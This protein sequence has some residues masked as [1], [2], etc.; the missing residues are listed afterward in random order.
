MK[1]KV[2][3]MFYSLQGEGPY[4]GRPAVFLRMSNCTL[5]CKWCDTVEVWRQGNEFTQAELMQQ[6]HDRGFIEKLQ[7]G[8]LLILTG[9]SPLMQ[10]KAL[11]P[12]LEQLNQCIKEVNEE[13]SDTFLHIET[14]G[15]IEPEEKLRYLTAFT[16]VSPK[17]S[18]SGEP[19]VKRIRR[20]V[21]NRYGADAFYTASVFFKFVVADAADFTEALAL[22]KELHP[23]Y[24]PIS[25]PDIRFTANEVGFM[26]CASTEEDLKSVWATIQLP[27]LC[28][29]HG[30]SYSTRLQVQLWGKTTGV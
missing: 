3:E 6:F 7:Q 12:F 25:E 13:N 21:L 19:E 20:T 15:V 4:T 1:L 23:V 29:K 16:V 2:A 30:F 24:D 22:I 18:N 26:P 14:E 9:G 11:I 28:M 17:L 5:N 8:A 27:E 10:Q